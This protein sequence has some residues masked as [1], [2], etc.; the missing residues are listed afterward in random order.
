ME[1]NGAIRALPIRVRGAA[2]GNAYGARC[3]AAGGPPTERARLRSWAAVADDPNLHEHAEWERDLGSARGARLGPGLGL[4]DIAEQL[5]TGTVLAI[6]GPADG[7]AF[8]A[9]SEGDY[10]RLSAEAIEADAG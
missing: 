9:G 1:R 10:M 2:I 8:P 6:K 7:W 4:P 3:G 5:D